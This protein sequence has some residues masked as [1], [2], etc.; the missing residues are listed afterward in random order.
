MRRSVDVTGGFG[1]MR[2]LSGRSVGSSWRALLEAG[3]VAGL[4]DGPLLERFA[5]PE[6][7]AAE[8]AFAAL[9]A[10]H[11]PWGP[12]GGRRRAA[13]V[14]LCDL[15]GLT[16]AEAAHRLGCSDRTLRRRLAHAHG[17]LRS[18]LTRRG[19]A[20]SALAFVLAPESASAGSPES[21]I[22]ATARAASRFAT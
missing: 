22:G 11:G 6:G 8:A 7:G 10:R 20:P 16:Q 19:L 9:W 14:V 3:P 21:L 13:P 2:E 15:E 4:G 18:R 17:L 12:R 5:G 1:P